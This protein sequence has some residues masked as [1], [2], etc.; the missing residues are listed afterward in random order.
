MKKIF[1]FLI[2]ICFFINIFAQDINV[3][4]DITNIMSFNSKVSKSLIALPLV[5]IE[6]VK[7]LNTR[8]TNDA[9]LYENGDFMA[10]YS[11]LLGFASTDEFKNALNIVS[12]SYNSYKTAI[13][14][15]NLNSEM[16]KKQV[17]SDIK[18]YSSFAE[19]VPN[20][21]ALCRDQS[22]YNNCIIG[23]GAEAVICIFACSALVLPPLVVACGIACL[24][25]EATGMNTCYATFCKANINPQ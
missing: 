25:H 20:S 1:F 7:V 15:D 5:K 4:A 21:V 10:E 12:T 6:K 23:Q 18:N 14:F 9:S 16:K 13:K 22:G 3:K 24:V 17:E 8:I 11:S 2:S 19:I